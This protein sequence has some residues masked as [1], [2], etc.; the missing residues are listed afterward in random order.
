MYAPSTVELSRRSVPPPLPVYHPLHSERNEIRL[1]SIQPGNWDDQ[2][3]CKL[4]IY[5]LDKPLEYR[6]L[7]YVWGDANDRVQISL[8]GQAFSIT[9]NLWLALRRLRWYGQLD[10][11]WI[12]AVCIHQDDINEKTQQVRKMT[13]IFSRTQ[14]VVVWLGEND[15]LGRVVG[16]E[17][18]APM[19]SLKN[20]F[21]SRRH[22]KGVNSVPGNDREEPSAVGFLVA[23]INNFAS[24]KHITQ[25]GYMKSCRS[26]EGRNEHI[27][28]TTEWEI[29]VRVAQRFIDLPWFA[30]TWTIQEIVLPPKVGI[31]IGPYNF[32]WSLLVKAITTLASHWH[33]KRLTCGGGDTGCCN[34][35]F[36]ALPMEQSTIVQAFLN[37]VQEM[38]G[39]RCLHFGAADISLPTLLSQFYYRNATD[40]RDKVFGLLG[41]QRVRKPIRVRA[42]YNMS[43]SQVYC[44][45]VIETIRAEGSLHILSGDLTHSLPGLPS[46]VLDWTTGS[47]Q[48]AEE[49]QQ[50]AGAWRTA[51][52]QLYNAAKGF[53]TPFHFD[54]DDLS[55][56]LR[57]E[58]TVFDNIVSVGNMF[59][60]VREMNNIGREL[61]EFMDFINA[62]FPGGTHYVTGCTIDE[63]FYRTILGDAYS[64]TIIVSPYLSHAQRRATAADAQNTKDVLR[65]VFS[66]V[67]FKSHHHCN[68]A[69]DFTLIWCMVSNRRPFITE[70]GYIGIGPLNISQGDKVSILNGSPAPFV[71]R[72][73]PPDPSAATQG[74]KCSLIGACYV[75]GIMDGEAVQSGSTKEKLTLI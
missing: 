8:N 34:L 14:E 55:N 47:S 48:R 5:S 2:L 64:N 45:L 32:T 27:H 1:C 28:T 56:E 25:M 6:C 31:V 11:F 66:N 44:A 70:K 75:H 40:P 24:G 4:L 71:L 17:A 63:A 15:C 73:K 39:I 54:H 19:T 38:D 50:N 74:P 13:E 26:C 7:S 21:G 23:L 58:G 10:A 52:S 62:A 60:A 22:A 72:R 18:A 61:L 16:Y 65:P 42:D 68:D 46:W 33:G 36:R 37:Q 41:L 3:S 29:A 69:V 59:S 30:R 9:R 67:K 35:H 57:L 12:D 53:E 43:T 49:L 20:I 51:F